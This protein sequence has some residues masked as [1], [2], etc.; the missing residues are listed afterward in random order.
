MITPRSSS[1]EAVTYKDR[2]VFV[3][4]GFSGD[5]DDEECLQEV[6]VYDCVLDSWSPVA[7]I[8]VALMY[9]D[10]CFLYQERIF[11]QGRAKGSPWSGKH[12]IYSYD[13][14][15]GI[16]QEERVM[17]NQLKQLGVGGALLGPVKSSTL[18]GEKYWALL[19]RWTGFCREMGEELRFY[20]LVGSSNPRQKTH[21]SVDENDS[22]RHSDDSGSD[23]NEVW[24]YLAGIRH[25][26]AVPLPAISQDPSINL[27]LVD[28]R[29]SHY[30]TPGICITEMDLKIFHVKLQSFHHRA[31]AIVIVAP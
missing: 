18:F 30:L 22:R 27:V 1:F 4:G 14:Q 19:K 23:D 9:I 24:E 2:F 10:T 17:A 25:A 15:L 20:K 3:F 21:N 6:E 16:W 8:P 12:V 11:M 5:D 13:L 26:H 7:S 28:S 31:F 29:L